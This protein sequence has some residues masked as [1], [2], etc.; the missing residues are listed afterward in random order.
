MKDNAGSPIYQLFV[1]LQRV[2]LELPVP[3]GA[4]ASL[5]LMPTL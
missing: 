2:A 3:P 1:T 4:L 5:S